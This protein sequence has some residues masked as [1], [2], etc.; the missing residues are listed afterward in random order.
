MRYN[1]VGV[2]V[3]GLASRSQIESGYSMS[4]EKSRDNPTPEEQPPLQYSLRTLMLG[5]TVAAGVCGMLVI[6][7]GLWGWSVLFF[8]LL[9]VGHVAGNR[10]G[11][12]LREQADDELLTNGG[13]K[14]A[15]PWS[16]P[17]GA[18]RLP[19][20]EPTGSWQTKAPLNRRHFVVAA[21]CA[22]LGAVFGGFVITESIGSNA[23]LAGIG[24]AAAA[25]GVLGGFVGFLISTSLSTFAG[26]V[27]E[28]Q[29]HSQPDK[30]R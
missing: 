24:V 19:S 21:V 11:T 12:S 17:T 4:P 1:A 28:A 23:T 9:I 16:K 25:S 5:V 26:G 3:S 18:P 30:K 8:V 27:I 22:L 14:P 6:L 29:R 2:V 13:A 7:P 15:G 20:T 10:L